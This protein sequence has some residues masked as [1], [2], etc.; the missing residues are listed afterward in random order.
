MLDDTFGWS[1]ARGN[2]VVPSTWQATEVCGEAFAARPGGR[3]GGEVAGVRPA[4]GVAVAS[5]GGGAGG[6]PSVDVGLGGVP[7]LLFEPPPASTNAVR[8][9]SSGCQ[10]PCCKRQ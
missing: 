9:S 1:H 2:E 4:D 5:A 3:G 7:V 10:H 6:Q 8:L